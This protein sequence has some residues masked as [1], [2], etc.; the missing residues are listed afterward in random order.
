MTDAGGPV[1]AEDFLR[2]LPS[3][4]ADLLRRVAAEEHGP[5]VE[6]RARLERWPDRREEIAEWL[7]TVELARAGLLEEAELLREIEAGPLDARDVALARAFVEQRVGRASRGRAPSW[8]GLAAAALVVAGLAWWLVPRAADPGTLPTTTW[9]GDRLE[10]HAPRGELAL[11]AQPRFEWQAYALPAF[12]SFRLTVE[13]R[14]GNELFAARA[15]EP[16]YSPA[17]QELA[18]LRSAGRFVWR[19]EALDSNARRIAWG[20]EFVEAW[21]SGH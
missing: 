12:G 7:A 18:A 15:D 9:L 20:S 3:E 10:Q 5:D 8:L 2:G 13:D 14:D 21:Y 16:W 17:P 4:L 11:D 19:V 1:G 6:A